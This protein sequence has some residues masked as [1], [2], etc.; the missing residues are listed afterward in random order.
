MGPFLKRGIINVV[1]VILGIIVAV[2]FNMVVAEIADLNRVA[3]I[4]AMVTGTAV[5]IVAI[6]IQYLCEMHKLDQQNKE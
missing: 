4:A 5:F 1:T 3:A 2:L 6:T